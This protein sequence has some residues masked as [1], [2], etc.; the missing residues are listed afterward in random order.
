MQTIA[1]IDFETTGLGP[2]TGGRATEIAAV[3]VRGGEIVGSYQRLMNS[4]AWV[5]PFIEQLTGISNAMLAQAPPAE[6]VMREVA[7]F[8]RGCPL[9]AHNASF[10]RG[11]WH[12]ELE[13]AG[14]AHDPAHEFVCTVLLAR[15][16]YPEASNCKLGTLAQFHQLPATGRAHRA[17]AD[18]QT[19]A[20]LLLRMQV[21]LGQ[22][23]ASELG[24]LPVE[25][26]LLARL[27]RTARTALKRAVHEY[28]KPRLA[29]LN[30]E[31]ASI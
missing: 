28:A 25:H 26:D 23:Y 6:T 16:L 27:Q 14:C 19:T 12:Y 11:F 20:H 30:P 9:V 21:D 1:V 10:D 4:G 22:R 13:R 18:A 15:R 24:P 5:P 31:L 2:N 8:T 7:D 29:A 17:L 3:L